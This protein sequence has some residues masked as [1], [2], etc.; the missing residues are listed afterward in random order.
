MRWKLSHPCVMQAL[1]SQRHVTHTSNTY[2]SAPRLLTSCCAGLVCWG[3][4]P[5]MALQHAQ[6]SKSS[7]CCDLG[8]PQAG[9]HPTPQALQDPFPLS[10]FRV[11]AWMLVSPSCPE[12]LCL[13][14]KAPVPIVSWTLD[15]PHYMS[16]GQC[17]DLCSHLTMSSLPFFCSMLE[18]AIVVRTQAASEQYV[19]MAERCWASP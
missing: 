8:P 7:P 2:K 4:L 13:F 16:P 19:L 15:Q 5:N 18:K 9:H 17:R 6:Q 3:A 10:Y 14:S 1:L 11:S 12:T